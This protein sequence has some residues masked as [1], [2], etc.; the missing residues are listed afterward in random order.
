MKRA[1]HPDELVEQWTILPEEQQ[2]IGNK[3]GP[4]RLGFAV[5]LKFFQ[6]EGRFPRQ[7]AEVPHGIVEYLAQQVAVGPETWEQYDW[8]GRSIEYHRAQIRQHLGF[9][10]ASLADGEGLRTWLC[11]QVLSTTHRVDHVREAFYQRCRDLRLEPP[12]PERTERLLRSALHHFETQFSAQVLHQL[13]PATRQKLDALLAADALAADAE[14]PAEPAREEQALLHELRADPGRASL[15]NLLRTI[16]NLERVCDLDLPLTL[17]SQLGPRVLQS[18]RQ[19]AAVE[20]PYELRRHPEALRMTLLAVFCHCRRRELTDSLVD[21]L[22]ELIHRIDARAERKVEK[23]FLEDL[24]RV[25]GKTGLL[26]RLAE[27]ALAHPEGVVKE[28]VF[29]IVNEATLRDLVKEWKATGPFYR[30]QV[31]TVIRSSY[32]SHYRRMLPKLL[33]A[34]EF[35]SNNAMHQP[36]IEALALLKKYL[37]SSARTYPTNEEV[38]LEADHY[39]H[40]FSKRLATRQ[41]STSN[42]KS[43]RPRHKARTPGIPSFVRLR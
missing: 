35:R 5:L 15:E 29:P 31:Q 21:V 18:Y 24:K 38:P 2:W 8:H 6:Q 3:Y 43:R 32:Q 7:S 12:T 39:P 20:A 14:H 13:L 9:R 40:R 30:Y 34:L 42:V 36:L 16:T 11:T 23:A 33:H 37:P 4:T 26:F 22:L 1:W 27:A 10:E 25:N 28:I 19:R 41:P 17:F